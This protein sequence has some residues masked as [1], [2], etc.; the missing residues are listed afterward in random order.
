[1]KLY[2]YIVREPAVIDM[3]GDAVF[4]ILVPDPKLELEEFEVTKE[5]PKGY[6]ISIASWGHWKRWVSKTS[7]KRYAHP[8]EKEALN[9]FVLR[10]RARVKIMKHQLAISQIALSM[11]ENKLNQEAE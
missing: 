3:N 8:T 9:G 5:T 11:A 7:R 4:P 2:R 10:T 6:W 1:M